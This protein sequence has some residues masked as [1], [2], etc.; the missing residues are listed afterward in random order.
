MQRRF[1]DPLAEHLEFL[2]HTSTPFPGE[3]VNDG[4]ITSPD[5]FVAYRISET[6]HVLIDSAYDS[7]DFILPSACLVNPDFEPLLW[8]TRQLRESYEHPIDVGKLPYCAMG[9]PRA[10]RVVQILSQGNVYPGDDLPEFHPKR[11]RF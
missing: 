2:L 9:D 10:R 8:F 5:R 1:G 7:A 11:N 3:S 6:Q 4:E